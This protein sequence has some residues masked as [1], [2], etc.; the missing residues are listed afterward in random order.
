MNRLNRHL[1]SPDHKK[2]G[3]HPLHRSS[4]TVSVVWIIR[5]TGCSK[6][7]AILQAK[8]P[9]IAGRTAPNAEPTRLVAQRREAQGNGWREGSSDWRKMHQL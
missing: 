2:G 7:V 9:C 1:R 3:F 5:G 4:C 8:N 6:K